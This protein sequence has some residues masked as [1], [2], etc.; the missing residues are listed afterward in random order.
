MSE[1]QI[2]TFIALLAGC[3]GLLLSLLVVA[4]R[5]VRSLQRIER[6]LQT[7]AVA[8]KSAALA[9]AGV[10]SA[11]RGEFETFLAEDPQRLLLA[12]AEQFKAYRHWR[13]QKG[14]NWSKP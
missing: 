1:P 9:T 6:E 7:R 11:A 14:L 3:A 10:G 2:F 4:V 8:P 5:G 13:Q 12:K